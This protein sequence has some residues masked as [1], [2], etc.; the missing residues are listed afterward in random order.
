[1][2]AEKRELAAA[3]QLA[4]LLPAATRSQ[5]DLLILQMIA[6]A[7]SGAVTKTATAPLE[8]IKIIFQIQ[9]CARLLPL[10]GKIHSSWCPP[11]PGAGR[12]G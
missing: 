5:S 6:G 8:R 10:L 3:P 1:M 7:F 4:S 12:Q 2:A 11:L 9:V